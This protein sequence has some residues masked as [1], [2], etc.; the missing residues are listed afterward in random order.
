MITEAGYYFTQLES[1][2]AFIDILD[3]THLTIDPEE[4]YE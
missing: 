4:F 2:V 1:A 3:A